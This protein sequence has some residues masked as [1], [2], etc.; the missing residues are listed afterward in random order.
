[1]IQDFEMGD[2]PGLSMCA[3]QNHKGPY[4]KAAEGSA[5]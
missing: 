2:N 3:R 4:M 1:M 5:R